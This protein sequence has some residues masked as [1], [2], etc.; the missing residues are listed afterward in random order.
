MIF[1]GEHRHRPPEASFAQY[2]KAMEGAAEEHAGEPV[3][4]GTSTGYYRHHGSLIGGDLRFIGLSA[5]R[6]YSL[7]V[8]SGEGDI[9][10]QRS[11][12]MIPVEGFITWK[13]RE[14]IYDP[15]SQ[16]VFSPSKMPLGIEW[17]KAS[18]SQRPSTIL[19]VAPIETA[20]D[21][22]KRRTLHSRV[23]VPY[24][25][26][27]SLGLSPDLDAHL[28]PKHIPR[29]YKEHAVV[30]GR[31]AVKDVLHAGER[32]DRILKRILK[33]DIPAFVDAANDAKKRR[34]TARTIELP[35][36]VLQQE[37]EDAW[38]AAAQLGVEC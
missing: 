28:Y 9:S 26:L 16:T 6:E 10:S 21:S 24:S 18:V 25:T 1:Q 2:A 27:N 30:L 3:I 37:Y 13:I 32:Q 35:K 17:I 22:K 36:A 11:G 5:E 29:V 14:K 34:T 38:E 31:D 20:K 8:L 19:A 33:G 12:L 4:V 15:A 23:E 7:G